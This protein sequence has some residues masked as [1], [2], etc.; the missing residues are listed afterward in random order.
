MSRIKHF[1]LE[2]D[3]N[4]TELTDEL[5]VENG[6]TVYLE[7]LPKLT[8]LPS[9]LKAG[10]IYIVNCPSLT[11]IPD[12]IETEELCISYC[13]GITTIPSLPNTYVDLEDLYNFVEFPDGFKCVSL[14]IINCASLK[15]MPKNMRIAKEFEIS[16]CVNF[17]GL[18][19]GNFIG[20]NIDFTRVPKLLSLPDDLIFEGDHIVSDKPIET[21]L[22][23]IVYK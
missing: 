7:N 5:I 3:P 11:Q 13:Q 19:K 20:G 14:M 8:K 23:V 1:C 2:H 6:G 22:K 4:I 9:V 16:D 15:K 21:E 10:A 17:E 18:D 12:N